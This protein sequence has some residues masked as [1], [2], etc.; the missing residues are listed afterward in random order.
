MEINS[1]NISRRSSASTSAPPLTEKWPSSHT[2]L[3]LQQHAAHL[4]ESPLS[5][6][7]R[8]ALD[9]YING[10]V[11]QALPGAIGK[12]KIFYTP[13]DAGIACASRRMERSMQT[14]VHGG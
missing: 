3:A 5:Q 7:L 13:S 12:E 8:H 11:A 1:S 10:R 4:Q 2:V 6:S 9:T 14:T